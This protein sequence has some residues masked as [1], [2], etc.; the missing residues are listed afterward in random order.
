MYPSEHPAAD[1]SGEL[2]RI[3]NRVPKGNEKAKKERLVSSAEPTVEK[4][5]A[6]AIL[7]SEYDN[8]NDAVSVSG[9]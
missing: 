4:R 3:Q 6:D 5:A 1:P 2:Q 7:S 9:N 8:T